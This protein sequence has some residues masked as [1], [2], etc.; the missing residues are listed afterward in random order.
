MVGKW[1]GNEGCGSLAWLMLNI[2]VMTKGMSA[3]AASIALSILR[4]IHKIRRGLSS[5]APVGY[6]DEAGFHF[7]A[8]SWKE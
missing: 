8:P 4:L 2:K 3:V 6:E 7:G 5:T 1:V